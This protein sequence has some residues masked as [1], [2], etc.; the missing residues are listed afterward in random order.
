MCLDQAARTVLRNLPTS[1]LSRLL[2]RDSVCA[3]ESTWEE[4]DPVSLVPRCTP[5][6][7]ELTCWVP[8]AACCAASHSASARIII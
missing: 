3:A 6:M 8:C 5:V 2:S 4:A 1:V 7:L